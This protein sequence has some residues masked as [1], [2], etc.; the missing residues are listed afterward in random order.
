MTT[1][2]IRTAAAL[3]VATGAAGSAFAQ[4]PVHQG[5]SMPTATGAAASGT[6]AAGSAHQEMMAAMD[7]MNKAMM[8]P[9]TMTGD[10][11]RDFVAAMTP[12]HQGA[13]DMARLY[14][15]EG[16]DPAIRQM[17]Q[18]IITDQEREIRQF[19][20]WQAKHPAK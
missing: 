2:L 20:Q 8:A 7:R 16:K 15:R 11:D 17:A 18:K 9:E 4:A 19:R 3:L 13:I 14:L 10:P 6:P 1:M 5:M 12:H